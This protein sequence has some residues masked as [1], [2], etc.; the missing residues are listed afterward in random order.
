MKEASILRHLFRQ[1]AREMRRAGVPMG[2]VLGRLRALGAMPYHC[3][4]EVMDWTGCDH[5]TAKEKVLCC[6]AWLDAGGGD[7]EGVGGVR[8]EAEKPHSGGVFG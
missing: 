2:E 4:A 5:Q 3:V 1:K 7:R 6:P 8:A